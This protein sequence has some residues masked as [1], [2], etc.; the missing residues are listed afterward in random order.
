MT[1][2]HEEYNI[3]MYYFPLIYISCSNDSRCKKLLSA[4]E[5]QLHDESKH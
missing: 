4:H 1:F 3:I 2:T 5:A